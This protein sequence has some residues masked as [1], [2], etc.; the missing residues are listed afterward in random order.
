MSTTRTVYLV[1]DGK[2]ELEI[3]DNWV[4]NGNWE[5]ELFPETKE[6][7][8]AMYP[9]KKHKYDYIIQKPLGER[10]YK[11]LLQDKD[12]EKYIDLECTKSI[13]F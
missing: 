9:E 11:E 3:K 4:V 12:L 13:P 5:I 7:V 6:F 10:D 1:K 2:V 8:V